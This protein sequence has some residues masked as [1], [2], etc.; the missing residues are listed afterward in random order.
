MKRSFS[1]ERMKQ[2]M[3][4]AKKRIV[5]AFADL[6]EKERLV[7]ERAQFLAEQRRRGMGPVTN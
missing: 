2:I 1:K 6:K 5:Q 3:Q 4:D 7:R